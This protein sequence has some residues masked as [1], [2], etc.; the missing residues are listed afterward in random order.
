MEKRLSSRFLEAKYMRT[1]LIIFLET[2]TTFEASSEGIS[3][4]RFFVPEATSLRGE[5]VQNWLT[6]NGTGIRLKLRRL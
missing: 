2:M 5:A 6:S 4:S 3:S 1:D